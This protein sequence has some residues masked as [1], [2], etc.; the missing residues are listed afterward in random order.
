MA[1]APTAE[2]IYSGGPIYTMNDAAPTAEA[3]AVSD[4]IANTKMP[5][6]AG[7]PPLPRIRPVE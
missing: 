3:V 2:I 6:L 7:S 5:E 4:G 1:A